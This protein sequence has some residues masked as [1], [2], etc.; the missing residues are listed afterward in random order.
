[1]RVFTLTLSS[2]T[3]CVTVVFRSGLLALIVVFSHVCCGWLSSPTVGL[4]VTCPFTSGTS[5]LTSKSA[6]S[7]GLKRDFNQTS[8]SDY[9]FSFLELS[10]GFCGFSHSK[11]L[12]QGN[13][14]RICR[15]SQV[16]EVVELQVRRRATTPCRRGSSKS[17]VST[18]QSDRAYRTC[19]V[20]VSSIF[21]RLLAPCSRARSSSR[22]LY[23]TRTY[24]EQASQPPSPLPRT[25]DYHKWC[26]DNL[27]AHQLVVL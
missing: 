16:F 12:N 2:V 27:R 7:C 1:M 15:I 24:T 5:L 6:D 23:Y 25:T 3:L 11:S 8:P 13:H 9:F 14:S 4:Q 20:L 17:E 18:F 10:G 22:H 19:C 26:R 21:E